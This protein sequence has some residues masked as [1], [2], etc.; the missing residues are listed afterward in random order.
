MPKV[1]GRGEWRH[2]QVR[3][4]T[5]AALMVLGRPPLRDKAMTPAQRSARR[6]GKMMAVIDASEG[7]RD[8]RR[9][10]G[11]AQGLALDVAR[12][13]FDLASDRLD[14]AVGEWLAYRGRDD[15]GRLKRRLN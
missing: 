14:A 3:N 8:R 2:E 6:I 12:A 5:G 7:W 10:M 11:H 9:E 4:G 15:A 13:E 1:S